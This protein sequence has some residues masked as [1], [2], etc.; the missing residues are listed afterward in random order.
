MNIGQ[1]LDGA[2][3]KTVYHCDK[4]IKE[5]PE[6]V[7]ETINWLNESIIKYMYNDNTYYNNV[8]NNIVD[9]LDDPEFK[10]KFLENINS[11]NLFIEGPAFSHLDLNNL[12]KNLV[13]PNE[14]VIIPK[15]TIEYIRDKLKLKS[16]FTITQDIEREN[17]FCVFMHTTKLY[18]ITKNLIS[19]RDFGAVKDITQQPTRGRAA[20]GGSRLGQM[21]IEALLSHGVDLS[22]KEFLTVKSDHGDEK[23]NLL[24]Q[25]VETGEYNMTDKLES[26]G[27][28]K[29]VVSTI[30]N[31]LKE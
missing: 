16:D 14:T 23:R 3:A 22:V 28:T 2:I 7:K 13:P 30:L 21:E 27:R 17:I 19:V 9:K 26:V 31:F 20:A 5:N 10:Q 12:N 4:H 8:K 25:V 24:K 6:E 29:K 18:K 11:G 1:V 15:K